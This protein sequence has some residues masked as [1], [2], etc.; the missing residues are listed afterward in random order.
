MWSF[1]RADTGAFTGQTWSGPEMHLEINTPA[2]EVAIR[3]AYDHLSQRVDVVTGAVVDWQPPQPD[4][5]HEWSAERRRW[6]KT[7]AVQEREI[8]A[9][10]AERAIQAAESAQARAVRE[11]L[12]EL[13]PNDSPARQR[14]QQAEDAIAAER[15]N[16]RPSRA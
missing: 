12:L 14:L 2:G 7:R 3:G 10:A 11:A 4:S 15:Q 5:D 16:V 13:L 6:L 9:A 1:Y 8:A